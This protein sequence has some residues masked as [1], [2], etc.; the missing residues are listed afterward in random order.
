MPNFDCER[1]LQKELTRKEAK[2][3]IENGEVGPFSD[4]ISKKGNPF[5]AVVYLNKAE[6]ARYRFA[7]RE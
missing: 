7:K 5:T 2:T 6:Q 4:L 1:T 3:M